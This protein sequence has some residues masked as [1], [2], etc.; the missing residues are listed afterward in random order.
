MN[1][2]K[3]KTMANPIMD[4]NDPSVQWHEGPVLLVADIVEKNGKTV[5]E[6]NEAM[7]H[8]IPIGT[9]V[10]VKYDTWHGKGACS[11]VHARLFVVEHNRDCDGTPL[12]GLG[13]LPSDS[14]AYARSYATWMVDSS[15]GEDGLIPVE[16]SEEIRTGKDLLEWDA[17]K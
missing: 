14:E 10:E 3:E 1:P 7:G 9:L 16:I 8:N 4:P 17:D 15:F 11:K 2:N 6:N 12:Y 5:R 13:K